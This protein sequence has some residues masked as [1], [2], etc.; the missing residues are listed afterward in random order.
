MK[1]SD[2]ISLAFKDLG[3]RKKRTFLTSFG[4]TLGAILIILMVSLGLLLNQFMVSTVNSGSNTKT[5]TVNPV[6]ADA[7]MP[8]NP[9][10]AIQDMPDWMKKNFKLINNESLEQMSKLNGVDGIEAYIGAQVAEIIRDGKTYYGNF[11]IKGYNLN[12]DMYFNSDVENAKS[13][14]KDNNFNAIIAGENLKNG[15]N[16]DV[17]IGQS[18]LESLGINNPNDIV[19]QN[20]TIDI[21]NIN[22]TPVSPFKMQFKVVGVMSK[23]MPDGNKIVMNS[24]DVEKIAGFMQYTNNFF[25]QYGYNGVVVEGQ[26]LNNVNGIVDGIKNIGY[27]AQSTGDKTAQI[28][29]SFNTITMVLAI[30]GII[31][32]IVAGIGIVNTM[33]MAVHEKKKSIGIMKA[34]G[35]SSSEIKTMFIFQSGAIGLVGGVIGAI[36]SSVLFRIISGVIIESLSKKGNSVALMKFAPWWLIV[37][38]II[39]SIVISVI[40]GIYPS[41]QASKLDPIEALNE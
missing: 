4:I 37:G 25:K 18:L 33:V 16:N 7:T 30:L 22:G 6:K 17:V 28:N 23:Y 35:A 27:F 11:A 1:L 10:E 40:A 14:S 24:K 41:S 26:N 8:T 9:K 2:N 34:V 32:I 20:V 31:V 15:E 12:Y 36:I 29:S 39:F 19:G 21:T 5:I 38:T 13:N 3:R